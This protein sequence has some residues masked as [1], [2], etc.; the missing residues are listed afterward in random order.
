MAQLKNTEFLWQSEY[1][2]MPLVLFACTTGRETGGYMGEKQY[3]AI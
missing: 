3:L 1:A 2:L